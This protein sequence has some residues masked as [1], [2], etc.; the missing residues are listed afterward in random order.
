MPRSGVWQ[1]LDGSCNNHFKLGA[2]DCL[3]QRA[4][5]LH[6]LT[7]TMTPRIRKLLALDLNG[8]LLFRSK[9]R[10]HQALSE[11]WPVKL[12]TV[13]PRPYMD[14][15]Q[16]Y[17]FH[18]STCEWLDTMVWSSAQPP[19]VSD[20]VN[21]CFPTSKDSLLAIWARDTLGLDDAAYCP[22]F[23]LPMR[24]SGVNLCW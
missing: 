20:M 3:E 21:H 11:S 9:H 4:R 8:T 23:Y 6:I 7:M 19:S 10:R 22:F 1:P 5:L 18:P 15:F 13:H 12:R 2:V 24:L 14:S 17:L 16:H